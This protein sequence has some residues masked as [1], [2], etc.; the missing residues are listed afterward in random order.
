MIKILIH[1][2]RYEIEL[3]YGH[4]LINK[5][6]ILNVLTH[7]VMAGL[8]KQITVFPPQAKIPIYEFIS[9]RSKD[10]LLM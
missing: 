4:N 10:L 9:G 2:V 3:L 5:I 8:C 7:K 1:L 6:S